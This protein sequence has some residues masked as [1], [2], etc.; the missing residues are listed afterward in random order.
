MHYFRQRKGRSLLVVFSIALGV[1]AWVFTSVLIE[2]MKREINLAATPLAGVADLYVSTGNGVPLSLRDEIARVPGVAAVRPLIIEPAVLPDLLENGKPESVVVLGVEQPNNEAGGESVWGIETEQRLPKDLGYLLTGK[3]AYIGEKLENALVDRAAQFRLLVSGKTRRITRCGIVRASGPAA[4]LGGN[5]IVMTLGDA[6]ALRGRPGFASRFDVVLASDADRDAVRRQLAHVLT[7][8]AQVTT[9]EAQQERIHEVLMGL[10]IGFTIGGFM[11]LVVGMFLVYITLAV[12]VTERRHEIGILRS[13][14][15]T[16]P[17]ILGLFLG[18]AALLG[19]VGTLLGIPLGLGL[20]EWSLGPMQRALQDVFLPMHAEHIDFSNIGLTVATAILAGLTASL[21]A[22]LIPSMLAATEEPA[23][24]VRRSG[25][26]TRILFRVL[27]IAAC[28]LLMGGGFGLIAGSDYLPRRLGIYS[29]PAVTLL[30]CLLAAPILTSII[31]FLLQPITRLLGVEARLAADNLLRAPAR[32]GLVVG[33]V[34]A[35]VA[36]MVETAGLIRSNEDAILAWIGDTIRADAFI[37][38]GGPLSGSGQNVEMGEEARWE[39]ER[40]F[41]PASNF[42]TIAVCFRHVAWEHEGTSV[43]LLLVA[44]DASVYYTAHMER[45]YHAE[46]LELFRQLANE[47]DGAVVS[48]NFLDKHGIAVGDIIRL[49]G[50]HGE[51]RLR[52]LGSFVDYSWNMG[53]LFVDRAPHEA[54]FDTRRVTIYDCYLPTSNPDKEAFRRRV[55]QSSWGAEH[56]LFVLTREELIENILSMIRRV[57]GLAYTQQF[58]VAVVVA[59]GVMAALLISVIQRRR[60]LG[61]LRAVGATRGQIVGTVVAEALFMGAIGTL[62]GLLIG[63]PLE[64]YVIHV[65]LFREAGFDFP[66]VYPWQSAGLIAGVAVLLAIVAAQLP[67]AQ[68]GRLR[69]A[70][71]IAYE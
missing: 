46:H 47:P 59:L 3:P 26:G 23:D 45:G 67:A 32:T 25:P 28:S 55:Q 7:G 42:R 62:L 68:A 54:A 15:A 34:A 40:E 33:A 41:D 24:V 50:A 22:A 35:G 19:L 1:V 39:L 14:G 6:A 18:E 66:V 57:Y 43:D 70:E 30:G 63:L 71:A 61:L 58:L 37:T 56:A 49:P 52:I 64:W 17:Q 44:L 13:L 16:R 65:L 31:A 69:I 53:T 60:E 20:A 4:T 9:P 38:S 12:S 5:V 21:L 2:S 11:A 48:Q 27:H 8:Q 51:V 36:L 29:G 10:E